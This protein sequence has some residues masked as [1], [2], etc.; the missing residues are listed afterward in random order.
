M[1][2]IL[3]QPR[4]GPWNMAADEVLMQNTLA[5]GTATLRFYQWSQATLS[6]GY[7]Q[8]LQDRKSH[9]TS[10]PC[11]V[12]RRATG[13]GA[14]LHHHELTYCLT[15]AVTDRVSRQ[16][17]ELYEVVH[18]SLIRVL[19][20]W[21]LRAELA[22]KSE[23]L[24][25]PP[26]FLCFQR[27][28]PQ[29]VLLDGEKILGSAQKRHRGAILQHGSL[30]VGSSPFTPEIPGLQEISSESIATEELLS[31]WKQEILACLSPTAT[32]Q[33]LSADEIGHINAT[34]NKKFANL[35][36]TARR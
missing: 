11:P 7:F 26:P 19:R 2:V 13:G 10:L 32:S 18:Q 23:N 27:R 20:Q 8:A 24:A 1:R 31:P 29:D 6:L 16:L 15:M 14:I 22:G 30:L 21:N 4:P 3:D 33:P 9:P 5:T 17:T 35:D 25:Q 34:A 28:S 36:W 12:V